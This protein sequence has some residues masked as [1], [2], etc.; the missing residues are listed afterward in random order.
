MGAQG[1]FSEV[2]IA[3]ELDLTAFGADR[4]VSER[5]AR[6]IDRTRAHIA[7]SLVAVL[8]ATLAALLWMLGTKRLASSDFG[9]VAGVVI[10][11]VVG[12]VGAATGYYYGHSDR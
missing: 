2:P 5:R 12:L 1:E 4:A 7:Y 8:A 10:A 9:N 3:A 6:R 11:P